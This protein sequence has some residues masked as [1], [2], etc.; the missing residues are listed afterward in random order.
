MTIK[1]DKT[2]IE[3]GYFPGQIKITCG[4]EGWPGAGYIH[5]LSELHA[6]RNPAPEGGSVVLSIEITETKK[7]ASGR[8]SV[9]SRLGTLHLTS[10]EAAQLVA[11]IDPAGAAERDRL[12]AALEEVQS[13]NADDKAARCFKHIAG[14]QIADDIFD[15]RAEFLQKALANTSPAPVESVIAVPDRVIEAAVGGAYQLPDGRDFWIDRVAALEITRRV[16]EAITN[17]EKAGG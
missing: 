4:H 10:A 7:S 14:Q 3:Q 11:A 1:Y 15:A 2:R 9:H 8:H 17:A 16:I 6:H 13:W 5:Q 12:R